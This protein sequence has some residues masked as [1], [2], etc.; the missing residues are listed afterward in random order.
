[1]RVRV[2]E[3]IKLFHGHVPVRL[4]EGQEARGELAALLLKSAPTKVTRLDAPAADGDGQD[5]AL[6]KAEE[7]RLERERQEAA[8]GHREPCVDGSVCDGPHCPPL[9]TGAEGGDGGD[10]PPS[11]GG[12]DI[13]ASVSS[14]LDWVGGDRG[15]AEEAYTAEQAAEQPRATLI[16]PLAK[17]LEG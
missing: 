7:E 14:V 6:R 2:N 11:V 15:R 5:E 4:A 12:L 3:N 16:K 9:Q 10:D 1:M 13:T 17:L 8:L